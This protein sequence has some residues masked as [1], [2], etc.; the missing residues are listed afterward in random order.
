MKVPTDDFFDRLHAAAD[1]V[2]PS[3]LDLPVVLATS[4]RKATTRRVLTGAAAF[5][6]VAV[7]GVGVATGLP[8]EVVH[9]LAP[10]A[11]G[12][13]TLS[14]EVVHQEVAPGIIAVAEAA[15]YELPD[16]TVVLDTGIETGAH[17]DRF[18]VVSTVEVSAG[19][20]ETIEVDPLSG[21]VVEPTQDPQDPA[22]M[23]EM[24][25]LGYA[26]VETQNVQLVVGDEG[27]LERLREGA[28]PTHVV[29][30]EVGSVVLAGPSG[31]DLLVGLTEPSGGWA[32][33][34]TYLA[35]WEPI[36][37][38][39][40]REI[41][42][43]AVPT[44]PVAGAGFELY[45]AQADLPGDGSPFRATLAVTSSNET[46]TTGG[47]QDAARELTFDPQTRE[48]GGTGVTDLGS[49]TPEDAVV[50]ALAEAAP[51]T[52]LMSTCLDLRGQGVVVVTE[53][54]A[55]APE[56]LGVDPDAWRR[57]VVDRSF[58]WH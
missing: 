51:G 9:E 56:K 36:A 34:T 8:G 49:E 40:D 15:T 41:T 24:A 28:A 42:S 23:Q 17:G 48:V 50:I 53:M 5:T 16:G 35:T 20:P 27:E 33:R 55:G 1:A 21:E 57:C 31:T 11:G 19:G 47:Y 58:A 3:T 45:V 22:H 13:E 7:V 37:G 39:E 32:G 18:L 4:R 52:D 6:A 2:P 14:T 46:V 25:D 30:D 44:L 12:Y 26:P 10:A 29:L 43:V 38:P 54:G